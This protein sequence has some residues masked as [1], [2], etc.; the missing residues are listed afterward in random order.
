MILLIFVR[1]CAGLC[2]PSLCPPQ[3]HPLSDLSV[4]LVWSLAPV[5]SQTVS[6]TMYT[7]LPSGLWLSLANGKDQQEIKRQEKREV[8]VS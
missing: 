5:D 4:F 7:P 6:I 2:P 1:S 8:K 3:L